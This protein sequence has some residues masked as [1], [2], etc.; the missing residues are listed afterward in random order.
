MLSEHAV[1]RVQTFYR[2]TFQLFESLITTLELKHVSYAK[3]SCNQLPIMFDI[4][5]D[6]KILN[7]NNNI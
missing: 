2:E 5:L 1:K 4:K 3:I 6:K 7:S